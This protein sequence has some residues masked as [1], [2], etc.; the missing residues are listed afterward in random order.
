[1]S[2]RI[3]S[4]IRMVFFV[5]AIISGAFVGGIVFTGIAKEWI[6]FPVCMLALSLVGVM[7]NKSVLEL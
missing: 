2:R 5:I 4:V 6:A 1:M 3:F 7:I